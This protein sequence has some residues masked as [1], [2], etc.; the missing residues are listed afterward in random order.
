MSLRRCLLRA[1]FVEYQPTKNTSSEYRPFHHARLV[2]TD[3]GQHQNG[4]LLDSR[5]TGFVYDRIDGVIIGTTN[6]IVAE[7]KSSG[8]NYNIVTNNCFTFA[9]ELAS[10][11]NEK[12]LED[13]PDDGGLRALRVLQADHGRSYY[14]ISEAER[15]IAITRDEHPASQLTSPFIDLRM[16]HYPSEERNRDPWP[17]RPESHWK[18]SG[19]YGESFR[20]EIQ[21]DWYSRPKSP[22]Y[23]GGVIDNDVED[24][25]RDDWEATP[26]HG[27]SLRNELQ[28]DWYSRSPK[29]EDRDDVGHSSEGEA[30]ARDDWIE[31]EGDDGKTTN[32]GG[33]RSGLIHCTLEELPL[34]K[35]EGSYDGISYVWGPPHNTSTII[36][37]GRPFQV[38]SNLE[39]ALRNFRL[40]DKSRPLWVDAVCIN[41]KDTGE[42]SLQVKRM[43]E[44]FRKAK[45]VLC[46]LGEDKAGKAKGC[47]S[48]VREAVKAAEDEWRPDWTMD[49]LINDLTLNGLPRHRNEW[50]VIAQL[51]DFAWFERVWI[52][53][54][55]GLARQCYL[56]WGDS[57]V[58]FYEVLGV[59]SWL[60]Y[61]RHAPN[62]R[63][64]PKVG[65]LIS[66]VF[67][68]IMHTFNNQPTWRDK[69]LANTLLT[70]LH[71]LDKQ[72][73]VDLLFCAR[74]LQATDQR[75]IIYSF[76][77]SPLAYYSN[78]EIMVSPD[79]N[80]TWDKLQARAAR[81]MLRSPREAAHVLSFVIHDSETDLQHATI[82]SWAPRWKSFDESSI[83]PLPLTGTFEHRQMP[84]RAGSIDHS[85]TPTFI[86]NG[87]LSIAAW[88]FCTLRWTSP[89]LEL[90]EL[91]S[92][93]NDW[94]HCLREKRVTPIEVV[95]IQLL[96][97]SP[98]SPEELIESFSLT[99][100]RGR[101]KSEHY[102]ADLLVYCETLRKK[103]KT[104][105]PSP[106]PQI[107]TSNGDI[108][109]GEWTYSRAKDRV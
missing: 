77:G 16:R 101:P 82:P 21:P 4:E 97:N 83:R 56:Y 25:A 1:V 18:A 11:I 95:W 20:N 107:D 6:D 10:R 32:Y 50:E 49:N 14:T 88:K 91:Q 30:D 66:D 3:L 38:T 60:A 70:E 54:E 87:V 76:S 57:Q 36:C 65:R 59:A 44:I 69:L 37:D 9:E 46:W 22:P 92:D 72:L 71:P 41:Q 24:T 104:E 43:G 12:S 29:S 39:H 99:L 27:V 47:F 109:R 63:Q 19:V 64:V 61:S 42:K 28:P 98:A 85:F 94:E 55:A 31:G 80:E 13:G 102:V 26:S 51:F 84:Y 100:A 52:V 68:D 89:R 7:Q 81:A 33:S 75:D 90:I 53:Q 40:T 35:A 45:Q 73:Y 106:F 86:S 2:V 62:L 78:G 105:T 67:I 23:D 48:L 58:H 93:I 17:P 103:A 34:D 8:R 96:R 5:S 108:S 15:G 79:Y 74:S